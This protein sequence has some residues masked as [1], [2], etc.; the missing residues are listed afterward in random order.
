M[1]SGWRGENLGAW[2]V[3]LSC[4]HRSE[5]P[6]QLE[7]GSG[8]DAGGEPKTSC[9]HPQCSSIP[10]SVLND[11]RGNLKTTVGEEVCSCIRGFIRLS[12]LNF[13]PI[14]DYSQSVFSYYW[15]LTM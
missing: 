7:T 6:E 11:R 3:D 1:G 4:A 10:L 15:A 2:K 5:K 14:G 13:F 9:L 12:I 8:L